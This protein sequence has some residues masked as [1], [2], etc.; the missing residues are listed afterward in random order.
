MTKSPLHFS[1]RA[2]LFRVA[3]AFTFP[4]APQLSGVRVEPIA[5]GG[6]VMVGWDGADMIALEDRTG[7]ISRPAT[8]YVGKAMTRIAID[9]FRRDGTL[10]RLKG[11]GEVCYIEPDAGGNAARDVEIDL[12]YPN[13]RAALSVHAITAL[14][15]PFVY[16]ARQAQKLNDA[17]IGLARAAESDTELFELRG[18]IEAMLATFPA[19]PE[20]VAVLSHKHAVRQARAADRS[21]FWRPP[22]WAHGPRLA[23][24]GS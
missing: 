16:D 17:T 18:G 7:E 5:G 13:W 14:E 3:Q 12:V 15:P 20:A 6:V 11:S 10:V 22:H 8:I 24:V 23:A 4:K 2:D 1:V 21:S 9:L 19:W